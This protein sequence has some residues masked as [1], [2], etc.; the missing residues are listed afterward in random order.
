MVRLSSKIL[1]TSLSLVIGACGGGS[2]SGPAPV[3]PVHGLLKQVENPLE[4]EQSI[5]SGFSVM[6]SQQEL[7]DTS[8]LLAA[9]ASGNFTGTYTQEARVDEFDAVRYD[10]SYLYV[11]PRRFYNCCFIAANAQ[12]NNDPPERSIRILAT[13]PASDAATLTSTIPLEDG[14]SVQGMFTADERLFALTGTSNYGNFGGMWADVFVWAPEQLGYRIYDL[15]DPASPQLEIDAAIDGVFVQSRRIGDTVY[16]VSRYA[17]WIEGLDYYVTTPEQQANNEA[18][19][20]GISLDDLLP[21]ITVNGVTQ[22]L[23][24]P[25]SCYIASSDTTQGYPVVTSI[26][27]IPIDNPS[28]FSTTCYNQD[29]YGAY[30]SEN[31]IYFTEFEASPTNEN[32][33]RI[34]KFALFG[35]SVDYRGS[36]DIEGQVW[37]G[38]QADFRMSEYAGDLR[39]LA[40]DFDGNNED[41]VDHKLYILR[42]STTNPELDIVSE[43]PNE[44][45]PEEI[46]KPNEALYGVRF[47]GDRAFAVTF[48]RIDPLYV[49][50][51]QDPGDP[52]IA[53]ELTV[54][55]FSDFLHPVNDGLLLGLGVDENNGLKLELFDVSDISQPL[56]RGSESLGGRGSYSEARYD[57]HAF[58]YQADVNGVDRFTIPAEVNASDGSGFEASG[59]FLFEIRDKDQPAL[60]TLNPV[61]SIVPP[62][63]G[64]TS[65]H[66]DRSRAFIHDDT[67]FYIRDE[68]VWAASW[69][70]PTIVNGPF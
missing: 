24:S 56:S 68:T 50:N 63:D 28:A 44:N 20:D 33:T 5:K 38:G 2:S 66:V 8:I 48:E 14:V 34:H 36:A 3:P 59:L 15:T 62:G 4:L 13:D 40:T 26:T 31:A 67:V 61:G 52:F 21:K 55:G 30:V 70:A 45:R 39:V 65:P 11:A 49:I 19:L 69:L 53:G 6:R 29:A 35:T 22:T 46:G 54:T 58:T 7:A 9:S 27:A 12:L 37:H 51:L 42:E 10:G 41:R 18:V 64:F 16:I 17:P 57:R 1:L 47:L 23:V 32:N 43:L 60:A 25:E